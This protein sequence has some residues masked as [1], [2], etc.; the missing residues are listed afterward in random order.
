[1]STNKSTSLLS[2]AKDLIAAHG[3]QASQAA[4]IIGGRWL[5]QR[6]A[7]GQAY[8]GQTVK[9]SVTHSTPLTLGC[10]AL[11]VTR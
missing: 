10:A 1:M 4:G 7:G 2:D 3:E 9:A 11:T 6:L 5:A 8:R